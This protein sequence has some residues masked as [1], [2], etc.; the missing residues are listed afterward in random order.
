[1]GAKARFLNSDRTSENI[2]Y[3]QTAGQFAAGAQVALD[4]VWRLGFGL[5]YQTST[6]DTDTGAKSDGDQVQG[7]VALKY[8]PGALLL[9]GVV[10]GGR[11]WYDTTRPMAFGGFAA[12]AEG[13]YE[14]NVLQ[15]RLHANYVFGSPHLYFK[16]IIDAALT[17]L[18]L[19][20]VTETGAGGA[21]LIVNG[22]DHTV[23]SVSPAVEA[24]TEWWLSNGTL[25]RP[26][27]RAGFTWYSDDD[28]ALTAS[29][30]GT[31]SGVAPFAIHAHM[32]EMQA[33]VAAGLEMISAEDSTLR[34]YYDGQFGK[35]IQIQSVGLKGSVK[36]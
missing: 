29:F 24:G 7:G 28:V 30:A 8:N 10:S 14:I 5:G 2:G 33:D 13:D 36:F 35:T 26:F 4:S 19:N 16:P 18:D 21:S 11:G 23:F 9:A 12:T 6:L 3:D 31:F 15:G 1:V 32:D 27:V 22:G 17:H 25:I 34:L 20:D